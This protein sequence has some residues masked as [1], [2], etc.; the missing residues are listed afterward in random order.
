MSLQTIQEKITEINTVLVTTQNRTK[1]IEGITFDASDKDK[2][3]QEI[4]KRIDFFNGR[5]LSF[6]WYI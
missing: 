1:K 5:M 4:Q 3:F 2:T 6:A